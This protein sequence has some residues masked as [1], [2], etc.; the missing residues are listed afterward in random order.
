MNKIQL[1]DKEYTFKRPVI[2][3]SIA[4]DEIVQNAEVFDLPKVDNILKIKV[5]DAARFEK[6]N[7][8]WIKFCETVL[9]EFDPK[10]LALENLVYPDDVMETQH[11][12][13]TLPSEKTMDRLKESLKRSQNLPSSTEE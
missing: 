5:E 7:A 3:L 10:D 9:T 13:F 8:E 11:A 12:F 1:G 6:L 2:N 4:A